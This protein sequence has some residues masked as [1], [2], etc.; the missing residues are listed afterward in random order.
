MMGWDGWPAEFE[1]GIRDVA[2]VKK[3]RAGRKRKIPQLL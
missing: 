3:N 2:G 1:A